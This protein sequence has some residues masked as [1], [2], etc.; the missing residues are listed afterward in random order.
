M[1]TQPIHASYCQ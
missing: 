1:N